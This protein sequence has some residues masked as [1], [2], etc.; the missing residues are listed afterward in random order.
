[1]T[2]YK[3]LVFFIF[4][5]TTSL[6]TQEFKIVKVINT[7]IFELESGQKV[8]FY[9]LNTPG[10]SDSNKYIASVAKDVLEWETLFLLNNKFKFEVVTKTSEGIEEV[11]IY[12]THLFYNENLIH[13][14]LIL[15]YGNLSDSIDSDYYSELISKQI[16]AQSNQNGIW[17]ISVASLSESPFNKPQRGHYTA[18]GEAI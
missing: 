7:N 8:K 6:F 1:M 11:K 14:L 17:K 13:H 2:N 10:L 4:I 18:N 3:H 15:G 5:F 9:G 12:K 16:T